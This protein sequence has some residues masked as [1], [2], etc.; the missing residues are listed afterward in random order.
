MI[1]PMAKVFI[2]CRRSDRQRLLEAL[3]ELG[4]LHIQPADP[5]RAVP[6]E[7]MVGRIRTM[8]RAV[9]V[10]S[11]IE[12][13][14]GAPGLSPEEAAR[15]VLDLQRRAAERQNRLS[16]LQ[17]QLQQVAMW[18]NVRIEQ[19]ET[20]RAAG[21]ELRF[22]TVPRTDLV[23]V[24]AEAVQKLVELPG[25]RVLIG[26]IDR[27]GGAK[28]PESAESVPLPPRDGPTIRAE[29]AALDE[30]NRRDARRL[31]ELAHC[32]GAIE[33]AIRQMEHR[34]RFDLAQRSAIENEQ[35]CGLQGWVPAEEAEELGRR[36]LAAG[37]DVA[38]ETVAPGEDEM[39][40]TLIRPPA[41]ARPI[42][43]LLNLLGTTS[44]Y[45]EFDVSRPF[46]IALPIFA[47]LLI[48][49]GGYGAL[50][51]LGFGLA[52]RKAV[53][54]LGR[55][56]T[57]LLLV[58]GAA[59]IVWGAATGS[60]FG[61]VL[62]TPLVPVDLS[63]HSRRLMMRISFYMG[64]I[65]L[66]VAQL[67]QAARLYPNT[68]FLNR[69][70]WATFI[71]G[72]LGAVEY[73]VL[74]SPFGWDTVWPYLMIV[75]AALAIWFEAPGAGWG[76]RVLLGIANFPL[77]MLSAFSDI[78]SYVRL[79]AVGLASSVLG[80]NFNEMARDTGFWP[81]AILILVLGHGLNMGLTMI[82]LFA[83]GVRLNM[84]EFS[85][86]LGMQ[87]TGYPYNPF[88]KQAAQEA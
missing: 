12:S 71:W 83:H 31:G 35:L 4:M 50:L 62:Y 28:L 17:H 15:E 65:H 13:A 66:A 16:S 87:W 29:A 88:G 10:L 32:A 53:G 70:G 82:A 20:L 49:D 41:W 45:R 37:L 78:I 23:E 2:A 56:F 44:G 58:V 48:A 63:E 47:A 68:R 51:C 26:V 22:Y 43:G 25:R 74:R 54:A 59:S 46:M 73:L 27:T 80:A 33:E 81:L 52:Y 14:G 72:V 42:V 5:A 84:L 9:Q 57:H 18:G 8:E 21:I 34:L 69:V 1:V 76:M 7:A 6:D 86:N 40:P 60:F 79:M 61:A 30:E 77:A 39:P 36:L 3:A 85:N 24:Q 55:E 64:A 67:M 11:G 38:T 75:G 19:I